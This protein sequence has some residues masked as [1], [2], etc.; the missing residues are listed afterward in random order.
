LKKGNKLIVL[1]YKT[2]GYAIKEDTHEHY[3]DQL[4]IYNLLLRKNN[5]ETENYSYLLFYNP[6]K[7]N[8]DGNIIFHTDLIKLKVSIENAENVFR[9]ALETLKSEIPEASE[10]CKYCKWANEIKFL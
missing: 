8:K 4:D 7:A 6:D 1:D 2:R 9:K 5:F 10:D 3:Q